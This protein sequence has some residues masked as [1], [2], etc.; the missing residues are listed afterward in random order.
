MTFE[1]SRQKASLYNHRQTSDVTA[2]TPTLA[3]G[4]ANPPLRKN[5]RTLITS[6]WHEMP[7]ACEQLKSHVNQ[8]VEAAFRLYCP[9]NAL[10]KKTSK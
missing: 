8:N 10:R 5:C 7:C 2:Y 4:N 6:E 9:H 3:T 1:N